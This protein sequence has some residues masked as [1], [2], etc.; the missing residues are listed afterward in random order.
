MGTRGEGLAELSLQV[1]VDQ[2][3]DKLLRIHVHPT[4]TVSCTT[5]G[6]TWRHTQLTRAA[7][8]HT[9]HT[10]YLHPQACWV[11]PGTAGH[12]QSW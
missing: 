9:T 10:A 12:C 8:Q 7:C 6:D 5:P 2:R 1:R 3:Q 11:L 4:F